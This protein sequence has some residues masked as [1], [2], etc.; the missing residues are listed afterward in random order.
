MYNWLYKES[1]SSFIFYVILRMNLIKFL[2][3]QLNNKGF[4][5]EGVVCPVKNRTKVFSTDRAKSACTKKMK[6]VIS[7]HKQNK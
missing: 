7:Q 5:D 6:S 2:F 3:H 4:S 1:A